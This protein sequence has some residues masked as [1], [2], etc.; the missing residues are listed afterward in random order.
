[1]NA[2]I[3]AGGGELRKYTSEAEHASGT[4]A[5]IANQL[6]NT[7]AAKLKRF[8]ESIHVLGIEVG[9]KLLPTLTPLI[10]TA[11]D[12]SMPLQK[13]TVVRN[14]PLLNLQRLRQL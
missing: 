5:K 4:T 13:W 1:M 9:Q 8:Q 10:K 7:D 12:V 2:L 6:N 11:T 3:G 14:K